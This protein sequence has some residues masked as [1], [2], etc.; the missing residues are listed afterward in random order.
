MKSLKNLSL[1]ETQQLW[2]EDDWILDSELTSRAFGLYGSSRSPLTIY[3]N[4]D[5]RVLEKEASLGI[6]YESRADFIHILEAVESSLRQSYTE[7][8]VPIEQ[9]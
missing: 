1:E 9:R 8:K 5:G 3:Q 4:P 2:E 7:Y 6:L